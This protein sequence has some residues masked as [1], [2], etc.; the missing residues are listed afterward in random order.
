MVILAVAIGAQASSQMAHPQ[1]QRQAGAHMAKAQSF[2]EIEAAA[3]RA[4]EEKRD[5]DAIRLV[6]QGLKQMPD[7][8]EGFW[9]LGSI[10]YEQTKYNDSRDALRHYLARNPKRGV[11]WALVGLC[12]YKLREYVHA[13]ENLQRALALGMGGRLELQGSVYYYS[14]LLFTRQE[15]FEESAAYLYHLRRKDGGLQVN[16]PLDIP[17]GLNALKNALLPEELPADRVEL[18][19]QAGAAIF[20]RFEERRDEAKSI[21]AQLLKQYPDEEGLHYQY[22]LILLGDHAAKGVSEMDAAMQLSPSDSAPHIS[23][24]QYYQDLEQYDK[25][26]VHA[27]KALEL[28]PASVPAHLLKG[29]LLSAEGDASAAIAELESTRKMSPGDSQ[30]LWALMRAYH[31]AGRNE[32]AEQVV[33]ELKTLGENRQ[34]GNN[35]ML[36]DAPARKE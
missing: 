27:D 3:K 33:K 34:P 20:A 8:D 29:Q 32:E 4:W 25:A 26:T 2:D 10:F 1:T 35:R 30:V 17:M 11:G 21:F 7:W 16:V 19:R 24:A 28:D 36:G 5:N 6:Q 14:A 12:D 22:G 13:D 9:Y 15:R 23:L 31:K 18:A